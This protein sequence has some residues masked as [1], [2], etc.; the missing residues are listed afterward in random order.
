MNTGTK[1]NSTVAAVLKGL[2]QASASSSGPIFFDEAFRLLVDTTSLVETQ[3]IV[4]G[5]QQCSKN[6]PLLTL[7]QTRSL[8]DGLQQAAA[9]CTE[10]PRKAEFLGFVLFRQ[11]INQLE[12]QELTT[13]C[14]TVLQVLNANKRVLSGYMAALASADGAIFGMKL[15]FCRVQ[16]VLE[17]IST[18]FMA[19]LTN[20]SETVERRVSVLNTVTSIAWH[21]D[22]SSS[23]RISVALLLVDALGLVTRSQF[24][25]TTYV[26][27][28]ALAV[29]LLSSIRT[30][31]DEVIELAS[32]AALLV[33]DSMEYLICKDVGILPLLQSLTQLARC[34][35]EAFWCSVFLTSAAYF[36]MDKFK[37]PLEE[38]LMLSVLRYALDFG[39]NVALDQKDKRSV[40]VEILLLPLSSMLTEHCFTSMEL[41]Q[42]VDAIKLKCDFVWKEGIVAPMTENSTHARSAILLVSNIETCQRWLSS[43]FQPKRSATLATSNDSTDKWLALLLMA[44]LSDARSCVRACA[45]ECLERQVNK[46]PNF[47]G[48]TTTKA[49]VASLLYLTTQHSP[50]HDSSESM[51]RSGRW[52]TLCLY[53]LAGLAALTT[54]TMRIIFRLIDNMK[55]MAKVRSMAIKLMYQVWLNEP[56]VFP[57]LEAMLLDSTTYDNDVELH[58][59]KTATIKLLCEKNPELGVLFISC[60][61]DFLEN[62]LES[63]VSMAIDAITALCCGD[64]LDFYVAFKII[65]Q[66]M[67]K[68]KILC[69]DKPLVQEC[70]CHFYSL[71]GAECAANDKQAKKLLQQTWK[72]TDNENSKV[73]MLAYVTLSKFPLEIVE[74][75]EPSDIA[76]RQKIDEKSQ[77]TESNLE[78]KLDGLLQ[79]LQE[80]NDSNVQ[81]EI[82]KLAAKVIES[83]SLKLNAGIGRGK[84]MLTGGTRSQHQRRYGFQQTTSNSLI[85][86]S[87]TREMKALLPLRAEV[88]SMALILADLSGFLLAYQPTTPINTIGVK[89]KDKL[90]RLATQN[91]DDF[92]KTVT[93]TL[94]SM[95]LPWGSSCASADT[96]E[97]CKDFVR[98][99]VFMEGWWGFM[100][101]YLAMMEELAELKT[102]TGVD[103]A[104]VV[105]RVFYEGAAGLLGLLLYDTSNKLGGALAAGALVGQ[106]CDSKYWHKPQI[107]LMYEETINELSRLLAL[108]ME[109]SRVFTVDSGNAHV[110]PLGAIIALQLSFGRRKIGANDCN[111]FLTLLNKIEKMFV[112]IYADTS[113]AFLAAFILL[114]RSHIAAVYLNGEELE[115]SNNF[116]Q[117][118]QR[119][120]TLAE[121]F[122]FTFLH[123]NTMQQNQH[124][125]THGNVLFPLSP[126][127][128][129]ITS[130]DEIAA[131]YKQNLSNGILL[132]WASMMGLALIASAFPNIGRMDWL[133]NLR[134]VLVFLWKSE[135]ST[136]IVA[137]A[138]GPVLLQCVNYNMVHSSVLE[139]FVATCNQRAANFDSKSLNAGFLTMSAAYILSCLNDFGGDRAFVQDQTNLAVGQIERFIKDSCGAVRSLML[140]AVANFFYLPLGVSSL[141]VPNDLNMEGMLEMTLDLKSIAVLVKCTQ[142]IHESERGISLAVLGA[143]AR[144]TDRIFVSQKNYSLEYEIRTLPSEKLLTK[145]LN[146]LR[147]TKASTDNDLSPS[148]TSSKRSTAVSLLGCLTLAG[149]VLPPLDYSSLIHNVMLRFCS[150]DVSIACIKF[151]AT[152]ENC[153]DFVASKILSSKWFGNADAFLQSELI[154]WISR[155]AFR[156]SAEIL[157]CLILKTFGILNIIWRQDTCSR[158]SILLF[159]SWTTMFHDILNNEPIHEMPRISIK[160]VQEII[161]NRILKELPF[162]LHASNFVDQFATRVLSE[163]DFGKRGFAAV[164]L[165]PAVSSPSI[166]SWWLNGVFFLN[167]AKGR[168][169]SISKREASLVVQWIIRHDFTE[170]TDTVFI[171]AHL[172]PIIAEIGALI[173]VSIKPSNA[174]ALLLDVIDAFSRIFECSSQSNVVKRRV[175]FDLMAYIIS[176]DV[177]TI[178]EQFQMIMPQFTSASV[179]N[180]V[181]L[182]PFGFMKFAYDSETGLVLGEKLF[183]LLQ[184][185]T[186]KR[187][188]DLDK[189]VDSLQ[190]LC[191]Q[192]HLASD[193]WY[194]LSSLAGEIK[195]MWSLKV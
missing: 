78:A 171:N 60:I 1:G 154:L 84:R 50:S 163:V 80:E 43:L 109:Q 103:D 87:A 105:F 169:S 29:N 76:V 168:L 118:Q 107:R 6:S 132:R 189:F 22:D 123:N 108:S 83:V 172:Q 111:N 117:R 179:I 30:R 130:I 138:L 9:I 176:W 54:E 134:K 28:V 135:K 93:S 73:R 184:R 74:L 40:Y 178:Y 37:A 141:F 152:Q 153:D 85:S 104:D 165:T 191:H 12:T 53:S 96:N 81:H 35:P 36:L 159:N 89:R 150:V 177:C 46:N 127:T 100:A 195:E 125:F 68:N 7:D 33:L 160:T 183:S 91:V 32:R 128:G 90:L 162:G 97:N 61:Q 19:I 62:L 116:Q 131:T 98:T 113:S 31:N 121:Y 92:M 58:V 26:A 14:R 158:S 86:S 64:C 41:L 170:W 69:A 63:V 48:A 182:L 82:E 145:I 112:E 142:S 4:F 39:L 49:V 56:R 146:W 42:Q 115:T 110:S 75:C 149:S 137:V 15:D 133:D 23:V 71:G 66:K 70:L 55:I 8:Y 94:Q 72:F 102:P 106:L 120:K 156:V 18:V 181:D 51:H 99:L 95:E 188:D 67:R 190:T 174:V 17:L 16:R 140:S 13:L 167:V 20:P 136:S 148:K 193:D 187:T 151:A 2:K 161:L 192:M 10:P 21:F 34:L 77:R 194:V 27:H 139:T 186:H 45:G 114:G 122:L 180:A 119:V 59:I 79:R 126:A 185:L 101:T 52:M 57:K 175:L 124:F 44:L 25:E 144:A 11:S 166:W 157:R 38:G 155:A 88:Q 3:K 143:I 65:A 47:W 24:A 5:L 129:A 147:N 164:I 173:A